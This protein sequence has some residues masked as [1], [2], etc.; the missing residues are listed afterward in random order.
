MKKCKQVLTAMCLAFVFV[1]LTACGSKED[2]KNTTNASRVPETA[3]TSASRPSDGS[4]PGAETDGMEKDR[5]F[6]EST[7]V[8]E[9]IGDDLKDGAEDTAD[10]IE[11]G[12]TRAEEGLEERDPDTEQN[13]QSDR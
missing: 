8:L 11:E 13:N 4:M 6:E 5:D 1:F 9:G 3:E 10:W 2:V 12:V 7:G